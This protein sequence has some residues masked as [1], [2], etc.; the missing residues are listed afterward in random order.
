MVKL[1]VLAE[2]TVLKGL[3]GFAVENWHCSFCEEHD[4]VGTASSGFG[5]DEAC[6]DGVMRTYWRRDGS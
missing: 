4:G 6:V 3:A 2:L 1:G 5:S